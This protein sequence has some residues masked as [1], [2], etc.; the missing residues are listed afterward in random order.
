LF[1]RSET[2][3]SDTDKKTF[4]LLLDKNIVFLDVI[5]SDVLMSEAIK[6]LKVI[7]LFILIALFSECAASRKNPYFQ[8]RKQNSRVNTTQL[9]RNRYYFSSGYQKKLMKNYKKKKVR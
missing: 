1:D 5:K 9:G 7:L 3:C 6:I 4:F 8:K 2:K